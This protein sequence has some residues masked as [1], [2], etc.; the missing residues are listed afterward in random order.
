MPKITCRNIHCQY[1][2]LKKCIKKNV[3]ISNS[4]ACTSYKVGFSYY[5]FYCAEHMQTNFLTS[6][7]VKPHPEY[8]Y[9]IYYMMRCLPVVYT[10]DYIRGMLIMCHKETKKILNANDLLTLMETDL[11]E[12]ALKKC[13]EEFNTTGLPKCQNTT[14][15]GY[16]ACNA[17]RSGYL[18]P[19]QPSRLG[20]PLALWFVRIQAR[21][22]L[23][24]HNSTW[25]SFRVAAA[26][27][28][29]T[30]TAYGQAVKP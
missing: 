28:H 14:H 26:S 30:G 6:V 24:S 19:T 17:H 16:V 3:K 11:D 13:T 12:D 10:V 22:H 20:L 1:N 23:C 29:L 9:S 27:G 18:K 4:G 21:C 7:D 8:K 2:K 15:Q 5:F 25:K